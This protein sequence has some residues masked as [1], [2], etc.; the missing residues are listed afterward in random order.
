M[1]CYPHPALIE[2]FQLPER[3]KYKKGRVA[4]KRKGQAVLAK[5]LLG[6]RKGGILNLRISDTFLHFFDPERIAK[7][8]GQELKHNE[9]VLDAVVCLYIAAL[10]QSGYLQNVFGN[11][12]NGYWM[13]HLMP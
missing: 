2:I 10:Y 9:D 3:L 8:R 11:I 13:K 5:L 4:E 7:L 6:L 1:E 12:Q